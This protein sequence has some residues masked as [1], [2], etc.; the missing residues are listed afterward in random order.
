MVSKPTIAWPEGK[1]FAF[2]VIDDTDYATVQKVSGIYA[3]IA[4]LGFR[5]TKTCWLFGAPGQA[6]WGQTCEDEPYLNWLLGLQSQG[7]EIAFHNAKSTSSVRGETAAALERFAELFGHDPVTMVN[8]RHNRENM[9]GAECRLTGLNSFFYKVLH[10]YRNTG[11]SRGH[12]QGEEFFWGDLC[13]AKVKYV[14]NF[15]YQHINTLECCPFMPYH[16]PAK[17]Y[18]N[19]WFAAS[20][21]WDAETF[22]DCISEANQDHLEREG[23]ACIIYTHLGI[24]FSRPDQMRRFE[25]L[26]KRLSRKEGWYVPV[27]TLLD[28]L[29]QRNGSPV[30]ARQQRKKLERKWLVEKIRVGNA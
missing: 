2:T 4:D 15:V 22:L 25:M 5:T 9:Y 13:Q 14:R 24:G 19:Y 12:I 11:S 23:G 1:K 8:H 26:M 3:R 7:F 18:V 10:R 27:R 29:L 20:N 16:D 28:H 6:N 30:I 21:G 17:P